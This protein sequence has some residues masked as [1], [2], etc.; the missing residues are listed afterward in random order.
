MSRVCVRSFA[1]S[2]EGY[3]AGPRQDLHNPIGVHGLE[4]ME[5]FFQ[6]RA[7]RRM[8]GEQGGET[9]VDDDGSGKRS[10][11]GKRVVRGL[12]GETEG[13]CLRGG[14]GND[15][16]VRARLTGVKVEAGR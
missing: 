9:G 16:N 6:T 3:G 13:T 15:G 4:L 7:W 14:T 10:S 1:L 11:L 12:N 5:W 8:H 2:L